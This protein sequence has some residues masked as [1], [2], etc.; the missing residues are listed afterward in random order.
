MSE[1]A[2]RIDAAQDAAM[3]DRASSFS[4]SRRTVFGLDIGIRDAVQYI[5]HG[6]V[7]YCAG[8]S[9][10]A[11]DVAGETQKFLQISRNVREIT[12]I[13]THVATCTIA[14]ATLNDDGAQ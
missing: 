9:T 13:A 14:L 8:K 5:D 3:G 1:R 12:A 4:I 7:V 6:S 2:I 11:Y 10:V